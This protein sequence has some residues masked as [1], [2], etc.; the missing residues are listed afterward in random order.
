MRLFFNLKTLYNYNISRQLIHIE[1]FIFI[2][3]WN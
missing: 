1:I 2:Q 3:G